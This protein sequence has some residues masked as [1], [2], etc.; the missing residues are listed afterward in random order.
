MAE[1][2]TQH[3]EALNTAHTIAIGDDGGALG[4]F[5]GLL[6]NIIK[7]V[8]FGA[9]AFR[10]AYSMLR[11]KAVEHCDHVAPE[12]N[13]PERIPDVED[14]SRARE[15]LTSSIDTAETVEGTRKVP[16]FLIGAKSPSV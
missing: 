11:A 13:D 4:L 10:V 9:V 3:R 6:G 14:G 7:G 12:R 5:S 1:K 8:T 15:P 16:R 2:K